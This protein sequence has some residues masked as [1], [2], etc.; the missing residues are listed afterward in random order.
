MVNSH[1]KA[2]DSSSDLH[3]EGRLL[4]TPSLT[5]HDLHEPNQIGDISKQ[6]SDGLV[7]HVT[8]QVQNLE[9]IVQSHLHP[10]ASITPLA[11]TTSV[12]PNYTHNS[13]TQ[14]LYVASNPNKSNGVETTPF[15]PGGRSLILVLSVGKRTKGNM[16]V[17][18]SSGFLR[19]ELCKMPTLKHRL[20]KL[21]RDQ[22]EEHQELFLDH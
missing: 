6:V 22:S 12:S 18:M 8:K 1:L 2:G 21:L 17:L 15:P 9:T 13:A 3:I 20:G 7:S 19:L 5:G 10:P 14:P 11:T 4:N 16:N